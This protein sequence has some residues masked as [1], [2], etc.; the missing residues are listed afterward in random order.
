MIA[1]MIFKLTEDATITQIKAAGAGGH[2][3]I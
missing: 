3:A 1:T 2:Y